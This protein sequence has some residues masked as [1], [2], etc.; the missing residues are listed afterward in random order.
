MYNFIIFRKNIREHLYDIKV[1]K[2]LLRYEH[3]PQ[4]K[5]DTLNCAKTFNFVPINHT[6]NK[7]NGQS[8][9]GRNYL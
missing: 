5:N 1:G 6:I 3:I 8:K 9:T 2:D 7:H 4:E